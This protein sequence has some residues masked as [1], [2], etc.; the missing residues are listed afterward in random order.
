MDISIVIVSLILVGSVFVPYY[1]F[2]LAGNSEAKKLKT[3]YR[4]AIAKNNLKV[5]QMETWGNSFIAIDTHQKKLIFMKVYET[6]CNEQ[7]VDLSKIK[8]T[9][10]IQ[11][12]KSVK[13]KNGVNDLLE[14]LDLE[15]LL[16]NGERIILNFYDS[17]QIYAEDFELKRIEK[18]KAIVFE[19]IKTVHT[20]ER[21]A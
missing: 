3:K 11:T 1:F 5:S 13:T 20:E 15:I 19:H 4:A 12:K 10:I 16:V 17:N 21:A 9:K 8:E 6:E 18:W 7:L 2:I 14:K